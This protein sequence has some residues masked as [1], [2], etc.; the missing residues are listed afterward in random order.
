MLPPPSSQ[1]DMGQSQASGNTTE[2][3][4]SSQAQQIQS[5]GK[6]INVVNLLFILRYR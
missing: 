2:T 4:A 5:L 6:F 1:N 3:T